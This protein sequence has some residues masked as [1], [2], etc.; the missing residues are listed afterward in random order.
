MKYCKLS[1]AFSTLNTTPDND[2]NLANHLTATKSPKK[3]SIADY[4]SSNKE[5]IADYKSPRKMGNFKE[6]RKENF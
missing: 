5:N 1:S 4:K 2:T 3:E 6:S